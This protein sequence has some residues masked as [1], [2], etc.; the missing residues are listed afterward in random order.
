MYLVLLC[1]S[2]NIFFRLACLFSVTCFRIEPVVHAPLPDDWTGFSAAFAEILKGIIRFSFRAVRLPR[3]PTFSFT[4]LL[5]LVS[6][7]VSV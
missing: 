5:N 4:H 6:H 1:L 3:C 7:G 2:S